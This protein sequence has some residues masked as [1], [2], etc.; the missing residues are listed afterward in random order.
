MDSV[1][2]NVSQTDYNLIGTVGSEL[3]W[4]VESDEED[5]TWDILWTD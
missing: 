5:F 2:L 3:N 1:V 4:Y